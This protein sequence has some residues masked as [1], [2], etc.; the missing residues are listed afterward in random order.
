MA[1]AKGP[2][3]TLAM[4]EEFARFSLNCMRF[5]FTG[6]VRDIEQKPQIAAWEKVTEDAARVMA[7]DFA[8]R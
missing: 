4:N 5:D 7:K 6:V 8:V 2:G 1:G 3:G